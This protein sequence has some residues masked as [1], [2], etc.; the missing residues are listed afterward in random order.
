[1]KQSKIKIAVT[2]GIGSGKSTVCKII[3][4]FGFAVYSC[5]EVYK[6]VLQDGQ[7]VAELEKEFGKQIINADGSLNRSVL[8]AIVFED[9]RKLEKLNRITHPKIFDKM[10]EISANDRGVVF[11]EVPLLFEGGYEILFDRV[12][13]V[14]RDRKKRINCVISRDNL[15]EEE[16]VT[17]LNKQYDYDNSDFTKYYVIHNNGNIDEL[18]GEVAKFLSKITRD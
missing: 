11:Y 1:M 7:T 2:G 9:A 8:S 12:L 13:V 17:R 14:L 18:N 10:F 4:S 5:D 6:S 16:V 15:S 3:N